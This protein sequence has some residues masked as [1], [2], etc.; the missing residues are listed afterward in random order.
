M[1]SKDRHFPVKG[2][3]QSTQTLHKRKITDEISIGK[4][5]KRLIR[6]RLFTSVI[7]FT[8]I[9]ILVQ[10]SN[11]NNF[12]YKNIKLLQV[13]KICTSLS[14]AE[15]YT[16]IKNRNL[17][18]IFSGATRREKQS[19]LKTSEMQS[20]LTSDLWKNHRGISQA[21]VIFF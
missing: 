8:I 1:E 18:S 6:D 12:L 10:K 13:Y 7:Y 20:M 11:S 14:A 21:L 16:G 3:L 5:K 15:V 19:R 4:I 9:Y 2:S 17:V